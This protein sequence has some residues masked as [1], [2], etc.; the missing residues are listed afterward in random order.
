LDSKERLLH[1]TPPISL[2]KTELHVQE[3]E[4]VASRVLTR[5]PYTSNFVNLRH[6]IR[7]IIGTAE[8]ANAGQV[9][10]WEAQRRYDYAYMQC[11]YSNGNQVPKVGEAPRRYYRTV[12]VPQLVY[13]YPVYPY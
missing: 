9:A 3:L 7:V 2:I 5:C 4:F 12:V 10:G 13:Y 6:P 1:Y 11:M 8:R